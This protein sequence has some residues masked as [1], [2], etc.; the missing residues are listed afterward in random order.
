MTTAAA[1]RRD[2]GGVMLTLLGSVLLLVVWTVGGRAGWARG[3]VV[4]PLEAIRPLRDDR[5]REVY[6]RALSGHGRRG[7]RGLLV[8]AVIGVVAAMVASVIPAM[9]RVVTRLAALSNATPW[10]VV[11]PILLIVL[12]RTGDRSGWPR[13][14]R[15]SR[16]SCR[17][18]SGW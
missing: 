4:T 3:M 11:G 8:G 15:C 10:V 1:G 18:T 6:L 13:S 14:R 12:G 17:P 9:R 2:T 5:S 7:R 16:C